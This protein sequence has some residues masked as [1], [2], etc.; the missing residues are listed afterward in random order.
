M[1]WDFNEYMTLSQLGARKYLMHQDE[2]SIPRS[3][4]KYRI[5]QALHY[6]LLISVAYFT[7]TRLLRINAAAKV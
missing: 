3:V 7:L 4:I 5:F 2:R 6:M 1:E